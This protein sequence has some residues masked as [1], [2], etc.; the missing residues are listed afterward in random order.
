M[1]PVFRHLDHLV[2]GCQAEEW[3]CHKHGFWYQHRCFVGF[4]SLPDVP[5]RPWSSL[6]F[7]HSFASSRFQNTWSKYIEATR[8][9]QRVVQ[10]RHF[11]CP[12]AIHGQWGRSLVGFSRIGRGDCYLVTNLWLLAATL[13]AKSW[14]PTFHSNLISTVEERKMFIQDWIQVLNLLNFC[15]CR[16][17]GSVWNYMWSLMELVWKVYFRVW[18]AWLGDI[19]QGS[20]LI[21][22]FCSYC[23]PFFQIAMR[24]T[25]MGKIEMRSCLAAEIARMK[26]PRVEWQSIIRMVWTQWLHDTSSLLESYVWTCIRNP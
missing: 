26:G 24:W 20:S 8:F 7:G 13:L 9:E 10:S 6:R 4:S 25:E 21:Q 17:I 12:G 3:A 22:F 18:I 16:L 2:W 1:F 5:D 19:L 14:Y 15:A 11:W 23:Q